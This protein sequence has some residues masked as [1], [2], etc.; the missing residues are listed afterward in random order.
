MF[1]PDAGEGAYRRTRAGIYLPSRDIL[2]PCDFDP[3]DRRLC[4]FLPGLAGISGHGG[5]GGAPSGIT[6]LGS[7]TFNSAN[8]TSASTV[9]LTDLKD[10]SNVSATLQADDFLIMNYSSS[11][12]GGAQTY[13]AP[14]GWTERNRVQQSGAFSYENLYTFYKKLTG[15][16]ANVAITAEGTNYALSVTI[17][18]FRGVHTS[19]P[20]DVTSTTSQGNGN[21]NPDPPAITPSTTGAWIIV[22]GGGATRPTTPGLNYNAPGDL[23]ATTN[24]F[25]TIATA[26]SNGNGQCGTG[27]KTNWTSGSFDPGAWSGGSNNSNSSWCATT[28]ALKPA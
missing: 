27:V 4:S 16:D 1:L 12:V 24:H 11:G 22:L 14:S 21:S 7:K 17:H 9:S 19:T 20:F 3:S 26:G 8:A 25:R 10:P 2:G 18:A 5:G 13:A 23:S 28:H 6:F 15:A